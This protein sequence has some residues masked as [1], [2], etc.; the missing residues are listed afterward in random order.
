MDIGL[1]STLE[2]KPALNGKVDDKLSKCL[3]P[4]CDSS[5]I[6]R[7]HRGYIRKRIFKTPPLYRCNKCSTK[8]T[9][10]KYNLF[11]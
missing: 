2:Q 3:C 11:N 7:I 6:R 4:S 1:E 5:D 10:A 8:F 9:K